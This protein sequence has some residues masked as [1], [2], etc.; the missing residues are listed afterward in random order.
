MVISIFKSTKKEFSFS[1]PDG[2]VFFFTPKW[3][4]LNV[5]SEPQTISGRI[6]NI[7]PVL[8]AYLFYMCKLSRGTSQ[9]VQNEFLAKFPNPDARLS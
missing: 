2:G 9:Y 1:L 7:S 6:R 3:R 4:W 5:F 8:S